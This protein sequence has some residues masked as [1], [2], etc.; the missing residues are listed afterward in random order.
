L[1]SEEEWGND[2]LRQV[3]I[4]L[5]FEVDTRRQL[6][7]DSIVDF[8]RFLPI[9]AQCLLGEEAELIA[10]NNAVPADRGEQENLMFQ[11]DRQAREVAA[12]KKRVAAICTQIE[13]YEV[14]L[15]T[16][17]RVVEWADEPKPAE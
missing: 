13:E 16:L 10:L 15:R 9:A 8:Q 6:L 1:R 11:R 4:H 12:E 7:K 14:A 17:P 2:I 5:R 3:R